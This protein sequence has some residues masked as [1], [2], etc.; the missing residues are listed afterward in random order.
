MRW[1]LL[2]A[3]LL[4]WLACFTRHGG[5]AMGFWLF[6]GIIGAIAT[7]LAFAQARIEARARP[8]TMFEVT[9]TGKNRD[10][11]SPS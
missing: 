11:S 3:T 2:V 9:P 4:S 10:K 7:A 5:G 1:I 8:E 6:V